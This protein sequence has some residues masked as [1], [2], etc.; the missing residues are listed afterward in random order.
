MVITGM[1]NRQIFTYW[2]LD[3]LDVWAYI[4]IELFFNN[5][6]FFNSTIQKKPIYN[7]FFQVFYSSIF[8]FW[9]SIRLNF[10]LARPPKFSPYYLTIVH[11]ADLFHAVLCCSIYFFCVPLRFGRLFFNVCL[12]HFLMIVTYSLWFNCF[13]VH[14]M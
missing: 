11:A 3:W 6:H 5:L 12:V 8:L 7:A 9:N 14:P 2:F 1:C 10:R 13:R 4:I